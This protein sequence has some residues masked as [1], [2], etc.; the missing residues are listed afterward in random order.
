MAG[1][2]ELDALVHDRDAEHP[3]RADLAVRAPRSI[4][5]A[6]RRFSATER[7]HD[8]YRGA[9]TPG[10]RQVVGP[11]AAAM[12]SVP[13]SCAYS[14][15]ESQAGLSLARVMGTTWLPE[16]WDHLQAHPGSTDTAGSRQ[17]DTDRSR[18]LPHTRNAQ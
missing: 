5:P 6:V 8:E 9:E 13:T 7:T 11:S 18:K 12:L 1:G 14:G 10:G 4:G 17:A 3:D 15:G 2:H 16:G